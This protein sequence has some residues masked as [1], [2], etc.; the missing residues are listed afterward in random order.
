MKKVVC[1]VGPTGVGKSDISLELAK[2]FDNEII[3]GDSVQVYK[4]LNIGSA[5][6]TDFRGVKHHLIDFLELDKEY[7]VCDFQKDVREKIEEIDRPLIVGGTGLYIKAALYNYEFDG[8]KRDKETDELYDNVETIDLYNEL[9]ALDPNTKVDKNNRR[10]VI[11]AY[12]QAKNNVMLSERI[13]KDEPL[14][15]VLLICL[16]ASRELIYE[17]IN[18]R[19]DKMIEMGLVE[20]VKNLREKGYYARQIGYKEINSYLDGNITLD[21]AIEEIKLNTRHYAK[22]QLTWF[23]NQMN[24]TMVDINNNPVEVCKKLMEKFYENK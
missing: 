6:L 20:E 5:K 17:R 22:R 19:V 1:I 11:R 13:K 23:K 2:L 10:R 12:L 14:Y 21:E 8:N 15:D 9:V 24:A 16:N 3:N 7:S 4:E 18:M